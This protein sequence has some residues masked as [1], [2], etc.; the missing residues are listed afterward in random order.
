M[1]VNQ[2]HT[3]A[4][5][6]LELTN[7]LISTRNRHIEGLNITTEQADTLIFFADHPNSSIS[8]LKDFQHIRHQSA[9]VLTQKLVDKGLLRLAQNPEDR[10][11]K[12]VLLTDA[13]RIMRQ[14][15]K[16]NGSHTGQ[17]LLTGFSTVESDE[18]LHLIDRAIDN[19]KRGTQ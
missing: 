8:S 6:L 17:A 14:R 4:R 9:Q 3:A 7:A 5:R 12:L 19:L 11:A 15:L 2:E 18:F 1:V 13:G 10:R 16:Q